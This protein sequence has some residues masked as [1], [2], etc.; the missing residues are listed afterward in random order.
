MDLTITD[1]AVHGGSPVTTVTVGHGTA[2]DIVGTGK[3]NP[4]ALVRTIETAAAIGEN[5]TRQQERAAGAKVTV[6]A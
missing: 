6:R 3:A 4:R 5:R 1:L 2:Y